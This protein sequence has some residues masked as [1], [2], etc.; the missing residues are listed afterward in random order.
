MNNESK[1]TI[2]EETLEILSNPE[3]LQIVREGKEELEQDE[4]GKTLNE[5]ED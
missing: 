1:Q 3:W 5:L 2:D 4:K